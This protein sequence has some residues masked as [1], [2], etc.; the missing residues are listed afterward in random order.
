MGAST[1]SSAIGASN[2]N[3]VTGASNSN[4]VTGASNSNSALGLSLNI[5]ATGFETNVSFVGMRIST[6]IQNELALKVRGGVR[7]VDTA[8]Q[9]E[10]RLDG[11]EAHIKELQIKM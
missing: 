6:G 3:S 1:D 7:L 8:E 11:M 10:A 4:S 5:N 9:M 2:S